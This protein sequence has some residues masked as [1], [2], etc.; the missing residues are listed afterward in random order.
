MYRS[1]SKIEADDI[2][3]TGQFNLVPGGME[4]KQFGFN[5][6]E[7]RKFGRKQEQNCKRK[8]AH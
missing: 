8:S 5:L 4:S 1:V 6:E 3:A 7:T 2:K